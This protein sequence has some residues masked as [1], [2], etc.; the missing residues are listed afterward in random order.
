MDWLRQAPK[1]PE[2]PKD[3]REAKPNSI[4]DNHDPE[5]QWTLEGDA[6]ILNI[7]R[8]RG[9]PIDEM[10][11]MLVE[12]QAGRFLTERDGAKAWNPASGN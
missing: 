10:V 3:V 8:A 12:L 9:F 2:A 4:H 6:R 11:P 7:L 1:A 5:R